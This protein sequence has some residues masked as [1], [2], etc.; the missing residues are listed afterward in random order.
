MDMTQ[1]ITMTLVWLP[2]P[3]QLCSLAA[4]MVY[5]VLVY[6]EE[7]GINGLK[8]ISLAKYVTACKKLIIFTEQETF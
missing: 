3:T 8:D 5:Y 6:L 4:L 2:L 1:D 7:Q